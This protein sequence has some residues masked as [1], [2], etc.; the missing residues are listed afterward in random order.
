M[1]GN[2]GDTIVCK[3]AQIVMLPL[4]KPTALSMWSAF[5]PLVQL[6]YWAY[7]RRRIKEKEDKIKKDKEEGKRRGE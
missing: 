7:V 5:M 2:S 4:F 3:A 6:A 1:S